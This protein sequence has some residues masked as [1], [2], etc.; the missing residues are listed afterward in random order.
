M[1]NEV[2]AVEQVFDSLVHH[3]QQRTQLNSVNLPHKG[4][5]RQHF[6]KRKPPSQGNVEEG[7]ATVGG[8]HGAD[9]VQIG[10]HT[11]SILRVG[12][13]EPKF[14]GGTKAFTGFEQRNQ[15][16][17]YFRHVGPVYLVD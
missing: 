12:K 1:A 16:A 2:V 17:E 6:L 15:I 9:D 3:F 13:R 10:R 5:L 7:D 14:V 4:V 8:V 11:E